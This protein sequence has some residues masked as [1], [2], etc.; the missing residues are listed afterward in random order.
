VQIAL[1]HY[2][3]IANR[4]PTDTRSGQVQRDWAAESTHANHQHMAVEQTMLA[5]DSD[6]VHQQMAAITGELTAI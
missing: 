1:C 3:G 6:I 5:I 2:V 4:Q